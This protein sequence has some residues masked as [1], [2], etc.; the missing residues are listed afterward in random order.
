MKRP[1]FFT[2]AL[3][4]LLFAATWSVA[5]AANVSVTLNGT[6]DVLTGTVF[7]QTG[8]GLPVD[9][10]FEVSPAAV[11]IVTMADGA[12]EDLYGYQAAA[13]SD[14]DVSFG[15]KMWAIP[16][17]DLLTPKIGFSANVWFNADLALGAAPTRAWL[18][19]SD[20]DG[21]IQFGSLTTNP[22]IALQ[23]FTSVVD[24]SGG[25]FGNIATATLNGIT[26]VPEPGS[27]LL[28][29]IAGAGLVLV[30][31]RQLC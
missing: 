12:D 8:S 31:R 15:S 14:F 22:T 10:T 1:S 24:T 4:V 11:T 18:Q 7:G 17:L 6:V 25:G 2:V 5:Q 28:L 9:A 30:R 27:S 23:P 3:A 29:L 16:D 20:G 19:F 26:A 13:L 21:S